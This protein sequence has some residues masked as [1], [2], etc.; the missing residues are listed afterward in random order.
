MTRRVVLLGST[1][2]IG[3]QALDVLAAARGSDDP[4]QLVGLSAGTSFRAVV[5]QASAYDVQVIHMADAAASAQ[6]QAVL[7]RASLDG[8][9]H[10]AGSV[11]AL[12]ERAQP[13][14]VL[15]AVV[16][17]AGL[18][19]TLAALERGI[20]V[21]LANKESLVAAGDLC[22]D[23]AHRTG[24]SIIPVD[25]EHSALQQ[26]L[27]DSRPEEIESLVL[28]ASGGPF[29]GKVRADLADVT[30]EQALAHPTW[31]MGGK[32]SIDS[33]TLMNKGLELIEAMVL[34]DCAESA[35]ETIIHPDSIVHALVR[36]RDGSMLAHL[37]WPDM[38]VPIAWALHHPVRPEVA[39][40]PLELADMPS[41]SFSEPDLETFRCLALARAAARAGGGAPCVLN[42]ANEVA[43]GAFLDGRIGFLQIAD[44][45]EQALEAVEA[46]EAPD[47][48][49][50]ARELDGRGRAAAVAAL[51]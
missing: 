27:A 2:S 21:A 46:P 10:V 44:V 13:D 17:F 11:D 39:A 1:G 9:I 16:G 4:L 20:D 14:L 45:V 24:A 41:L 3:E 33:A 25:S 48:L 23:V 15:N 50:A 49:E 34:F 42:A 35:I 6:A 30:V 37:G 18:E 12:L 47:S 22:L 8:D 43:V 38:R 19:A 7:G 26:C 32:I 29:R 28:T 36:H 5:R 31:Q 51:A 40:R